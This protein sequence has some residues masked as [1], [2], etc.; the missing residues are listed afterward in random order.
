MIC[1][2]HADV[3]L[4]QDGA[5]KAAIYASPEVMAADQPADPNVQN[6]AYFNEM[7]R[8]KLRESVKDLA[9]YL[10]K[11]SG[12]KVEVFPRAPQDGD[13]LLPILVGDLATKVFGEPGKKNSFKQGWRMVVTNKGIGLLGQS[14]EAASYAVYELL[15][16]LGCRWYMPSD[17]GECIPQMK[18]ISFPALDVSGLPGTDSRWIWYADDA[19]RRRTRH[20][21]YNFNGGHA[22]EINENYVTNAQLKEHPDWVG[23]KDGKKLP[24]RFCWANPGLR[25]AVAAGVI[26][27]LDKSYVPAISIGPEDGC[28]FCECP[29]CKALDAGDMD[30][31]MGCVSITDR[32]M[33]FC[34]AI[35]EK[36]CK[37]YPDVILCYLAYV[38]YTRPPVREKLHPNLAP[39][40]APIT[41]CRAHTMTDPKCPSRQTLRP[42]VEGWGKAAGR[43]AYYN[44]MFHLA[45]VSVPY[46]MMTQMSTELPI[47]FAN[48][49]KHWSPENMPTFDSNLPGL[50]LTIRMA[51]NTQAKPAEILDEFF[52][53]FYGAAEVPMRRY[54]QTIDDA[55][56]QNPEHGG[57]LFGYGKRFT[58]EVLQKARE[59]ITAGYAACKTP[60]EK[61]RVKICDE[62]LKQFELFMKLRRDLYEGR[63]ENLKKDSDAWFAHQVELGAQYAPQYAFESVGWTP[64][65][66]EGKDITI[67][68]HYYNIFCRP[69]YD[70]AGR[71]TQNF[72]VISKP[73]R[74]WRYQV[75]K[76]KKGLAQGWNKVDFDDKAWKT[77][78]PCL[79]TWIMMDLERYYGPMWYRDKIK[80]P[81]IP[82]GK[83]VFLWVSSTDGS[84]KVFINGQPIP[85]V[86]DKGEKSDEAPSNFCQPFSFDVTAAVKPDAENQVT[87]ASTRTFLNELGTGGLLGPVLFYSE[88]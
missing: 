57:C 23:E 6:P 20:G 83:K 58:P 49:V 65:T 53:R 70:D 48:N 87:I 44:Y 76:E 24:N 60:V 72:K 79:D 52:K 2:L 71:I 13:K 80:L 62:S 11:I 50:N 35:A 74:S 9:L 29:K 73:M 68:G 25:D 4:V 84:C 17:M 26:A 61:E 64:K 88:K 21:G 55:W 86:N 1:P 36:V 5:A 33:N 3:F 69:S 40:I 18:T 43:V 63:I 39:V 82:A 75:D 85:Y 31:S 30:S 28:D 56:I 47:L 7:D 51:W 66:P 67:S 8:R 27:R 46:P 54:W 41:Y 14:S 77:T 34:N 12:A 81:A 16:R 15:E 38:Q 37:K 22:L 45:E 78:D 42:I 59:A 32:Y 19:F 10:E